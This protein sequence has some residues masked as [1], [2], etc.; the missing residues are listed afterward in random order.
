MQF[1]F[2][3]EI[4]SDGNQRLDAFQP[5]TT[6]FSRDSMGGRKSSFWGKTPLADVRWPRTFFSE[7]GWP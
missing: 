5:I 7:V 3:D 6:G 2:F 4:G 1:G